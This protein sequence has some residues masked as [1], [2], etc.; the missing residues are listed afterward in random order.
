MKF[1]SAQF[2]TVIQGEMLKY[3][4]LEVHFHNEERSEFYSLEGT[5]FAERSDLADLNNDWDTNKLVVKLQLPVN[6]WGY[7]HIVEDS[8]G[9]Y[10]AVII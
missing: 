9:V 1:K 8:D 4:D 5:D 7:T 3:N 10:F 6:E 2:I